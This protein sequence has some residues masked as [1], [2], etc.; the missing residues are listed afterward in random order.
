MGEPTIINEKFMGNRRVIVVRHV[1]ILY[2]CSI[3]SV[4]FIYR[5][6]MVKHCVNDRMVTSGHTHRSSHAAVVNNGHINVT[7]SLEYS[8]KAAAVD[9]HGLSAISTGEI[10]CFSS[11]VPPDVIRTALLVCHAPHYQ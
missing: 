9:L 10:G 6:E 3:I 1:N 2:A 4:S 7:Y 11:S 8:R 5:V